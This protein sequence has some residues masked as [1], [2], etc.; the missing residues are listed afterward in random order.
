MQGL[1]R[2]AIPCGQSKIPV[3][4]IQTATKPL[5]NPGEHERAHT[6]AFKCRRNLPIKGF[7]L[8]PFAVA[9]AV[10]PE[11]GHHQR[12]LTGEILQAS[13]V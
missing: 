13:E 6:A 11:L 12:T 7:S 8:T 2:L 3:D 10:E 9:F 5:V 4:Y 1:L